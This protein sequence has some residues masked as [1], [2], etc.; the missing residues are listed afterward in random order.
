ML[1]DFTRRAC[2]LDKQHLFSPPGLSRLYR[3]TADTKR[4]RFDPILPNVFSSILC[5]DHFLSISS[6]IPSIF[7][8]ILKLSNNQ[9]NEPCKVIHTK[10]ALSK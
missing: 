10:L 5:M 1:D 7:E 3:K 6:C 4:F 9:R 2:D 8:V